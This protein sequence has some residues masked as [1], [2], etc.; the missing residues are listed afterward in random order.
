MQ[1]RQTVSKDTKFI[2]LF[3]D[4]TVI[5]NAKKALERRVYDSRIGATLWNVDEKE[6]FQRV[7]YMGIV[8]M[9]NDRDDVFEAAFFMDTNGK[10]WYKAAKDFL[11]Q[12]RQ[13]PLYT[14]LKLEFLEYG[15]RNK[16][17]FNVVELEN[18]P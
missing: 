18:I 14:N 9:D 10:V 15:K 8:A 11:D 12:V 13:Y 7:T 4:N 6:V 2:T 16:Q 17:L 5:Q 3:C 1:V